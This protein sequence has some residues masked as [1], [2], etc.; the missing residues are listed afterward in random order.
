LL[1]GAVSFE[2]IGP[3][4]ASWMRKVGW[5]LSV[6]EDESFH[7]A[8]A[9]GMASHAVPVMLP[10]PGVENIY[11]SRW[12]HET[13]FAASE[14]IRRGVLEGSWLEQGRE[15]NEYVQ[16]YSVE[17]TLPLWDRVVFEGSRSPSVSRR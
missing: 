11:P 14:A 6:S 13:V 1:R 2:P 16:R 3:D 7:L 10:W 8:P 5:V 9:E 15:A 4:V 12:I 17:T